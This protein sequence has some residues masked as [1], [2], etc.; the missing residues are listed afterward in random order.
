MSR[1][2]RADCTASA[3]AFATAKRLDGSRAPPLYMKMSRLTQFM[4]FCGRPERSLGPGVTFIIIELSLRD[5]LQ[6]SAVQLL[7]RNFSLENFCWCCEIFVVGLLLPEFLLL[8]NTTKVPQRKFSDRQEFYNENFAAKVLQQTVT[9]FEH[10][11]HL[12]TS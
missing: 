3:T 1:H 4:G 10:R 7:S 2:M 12:Q 6:N 5:C 8:Y 11:H 9:T